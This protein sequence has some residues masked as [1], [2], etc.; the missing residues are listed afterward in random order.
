M[1][2]AIR[3]HHVS[4]TLVWAAAAIER[5]HNVLD[6][7]VI[8]PPPRCDPIFTDPPPPPFDKCLVPRW[9]Q[10]ELVAEL[11]HRLSVTVR[12]CADALEGLDPQPDRAAG[13]GMRQLMGASLVERG[14]DDALP[15]RLLL[16]L[17]SGGAVAG[18]A[19]GRSRGGRW[20][21]CWRPA[22]RSRCSSAAA[23]RCWPGRCCAARSTT[24]LPPAAAGAGV[25][26]C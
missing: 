10:D 17:P 9:H 3:V 11:V 2:E 16:L 26:R 20:T 18:S 13:V 8:A 12:A 6:D 7:D 14:P 19:L 25:G 5:L 15:G 24:S 23:S 22:G 21:V 1:P 4:Q